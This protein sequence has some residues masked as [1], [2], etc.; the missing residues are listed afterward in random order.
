MS[1]KF[2][3]IVLSTAL[4]FCMSFTGFA[5][6]WQYYDQNGYW[7]YGIN[8]DNT[9]RCRSG[10]YLL[11]GDGDGIAQWYSFQA[12]GYMLSDCETFD[13]YTVNEDGAWTVDGI[14]QNREVNG[15]TTAELLWYGNF[16][17]G[18]DG[19]T[20]HVYYVSPSEVYAYFYGYGDDGE[21]EEDCYLEFTDATKRVAAAPVYGME[22]DLLGEDTYTISEDGTYIKVDSQSFKAGE[23]YRY[24]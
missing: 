6:G 3:T 14:V 20:I 12:D 22:G 18:E 11:D 24:D 1:K 16:V 19:Q 4:V 13:G 10:W 23:Y 17:C 21:Y 15:L 7:W 2:M 8:E 9:V 5:T